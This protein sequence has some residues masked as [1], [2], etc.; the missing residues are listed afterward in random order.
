M[1]TD[2]A[3]AMSTM[4]SDP[5]VSSLNTTHVVSTVVE[6]HGPQTHLTDHDARFASL[7]WLQISSCNVDHGGA[8]CPW[9]TLEAKP[10][11]RRWRALLRWRL[12][13]RSSSAHK[14]GGR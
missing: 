4:R 2:S 7:D 6:T 3:S 10:V 5:V 14:V 11:K 1:S 12:S 9:E 8:P 13:L